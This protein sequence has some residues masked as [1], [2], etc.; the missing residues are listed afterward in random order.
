MLKAN[1]YDPAGLLAAVTD[2]IGRVTNYAYDPNQEL[3]ATTT[4][5][6][7]SNT[8][9]PTTDT[10]DSAGNQVSQSVNGLSGGLLT[11]TTVTNYTVDAADR[12]TSSVLDPTGSTGSPP[13][14]TTTDDNV[15]SQTLSDSGGSTQTTA[16]TPPETRPAR[17]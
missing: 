10:Y 5:A 2:A 13:T 14:P 4:T 6:P 15:T 9:T 11:A 3:I 7:S 17:R 8:C 1:T 12:V 16:T